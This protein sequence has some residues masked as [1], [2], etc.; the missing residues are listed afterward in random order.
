MQAASC[1][2]VSRLTLR[3][4]SGPISAAGARAREPFIR[5]PGVNE[6]VGQLPAAVREGEIV[7][8][9]YRIERVVGAGAMGVVVAARHLLLEER[10]AIKFLLPS[11]LDSRDAVARFMREAR[12]AVKIKS[13]HVARVSDVG[14]LEDGT[15]YI[16]MEFLEGLDLAAW[17]YERGPLPA[18]QA[19]EFVLQA[20]E[21][22]AEAH[23]LGIVH[24]DL[25]PANLFVVQRV[26]GVHA[27]K[28]LDFG[29][30]KI[31][32]AAA[33]AS[34]TDTTTVMGSPSY[35]SPEQMES[36]H[37]VDAQTDIWALGA[38]LC[39]LVTGKRPY[40]GRSL[41]E[42]YATIVA[43]PQPRLQALS[44][45]LS[46]DLEAVILK[47][48]QRNRAL[49]Y[50]HVGELAAA[51]MLFAPK[52]A[53]ASIDR[54]TRVFSASAGSGPSSD[55]AHPP[56]WSGPHTLSVDK[57]L[58][59]ER[60]APRTIAANRGAALVRV[61]A[62]S[63]LLALPVVLTWALLAMP[64]E[65]PGRA[66]A[67]SPGVAPAAD[68]P[69]AAGLPLPGEAAPPVA[70]APQALPTSTVALGPPPARVVPDRAGPRGAVDR[71]PAAV[72]PLATPASERA[73]VTAEAQAAPQAGPPAERATT[74]A[75]PPTASGPDPA[76]DDIRRALEIRK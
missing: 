54:I 50:R 53:H 57:T 38:I 59:S 46:A 48:L 13:E 11:A 2:K 3:V 66:T 16:V 43:Q 49:R 55:P 15:P 75:P 17:L 14:V 40:G 19:V 51:L 20:C 29:I 65:R 44:P 41:P 69:R 31:T 47:C 71:T 4:V 45:D 42:V 74:A 5:G 28:V 61:V 56:S 62:A 21:A 6:E 30:S 1:C 10:V 64:A 23:S 72:S 73:T 18:A 25:K 60:D 7:G 12:A 9:K 22:I 33:G 24:R 36:S 34:I 68:A 37:N 32:G 35:M 26:D 70:P 39:E 8:G 58:A 76:V 67:A 63:S 27:I 52:R